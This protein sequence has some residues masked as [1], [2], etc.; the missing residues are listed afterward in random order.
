MPIN[1]I[2]IYRHL[3]QL[4]L[5]YEMKL[6]SQP[7][8]SISFMIIIIVLRI[9]KI[10]NNNNVLLLMGSSIVSVILKLIFR[11]ERPYSKSDVVNN[12]SGKNHN[13]IFDKYS[14]PSGHTLTSTILTL[15]MLEKY[16]NE[17]IYNII[18]VIVGFSRI[19]LGVHYP[20]DILGGLFFGYIYYNIFIKFTQV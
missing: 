15:L 12:Y 8:N 14:F 2:E 7:F 20:S 4:D 1:E 10:I 5:V 18:P 17:F 13:T 19:F 9:Y 16:P 6:V 11:R 3:Q